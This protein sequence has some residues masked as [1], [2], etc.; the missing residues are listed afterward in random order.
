MW[1]CFCKEVEIFGRGV[2]FLSLKSYHE[3]DLFESQPIGREKE[4]SKTKV[5]GEKIFILIKFDDEK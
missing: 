2:S 4:S 5:S 3:L 1:G